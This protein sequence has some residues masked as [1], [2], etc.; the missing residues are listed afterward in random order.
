MTPYRTRRELSKLSLAAVLKELD[1]LKIEPSEQVAFCED[2]P[3]VN[4]CVTTGEPPTYLTESQ[5]EE[6]RATGRTVIT[7]RQQV[8]RQTHQRN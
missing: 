2:G 1:T 8:E 5:R 4:G 6:C 7:L 3:V